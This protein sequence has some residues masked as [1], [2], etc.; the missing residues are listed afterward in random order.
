MFHIVAASSLFHSINSLN[1]GEKKQYESL[2]TAIPGLS[3]NNNLLNQGKNLRRL[4]EDSPLKE[5]KVVVWHDVVNNTISSHRTNNY[6]PAGV[7]ELTNYL[8]TKKQQILAIVYCRRE[9]T[10]DLF[11]QLLGGTRV[12]II[13]ATKR[14]LSKSKQNNPEQLKEYLK[15]HQSADLELKSLRLVVAHKERLSE[16]IGNIRGK[17]QRPSQTR[18]KAKARREQKLR[19]EEVSALQRQG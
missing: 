15:L 7:E 11:S 12:L 8:K 14:L 9:G 4:L 1:T 6:R 10:P 18:R 17:Q 5:K 16:L 13:P 2:V 3:L 19:A